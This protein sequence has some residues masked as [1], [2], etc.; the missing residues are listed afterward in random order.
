MP[1]SEM[2]RILQSRDRGQ[3]SATAP[4]QGLTLWRVDY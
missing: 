1:A 4:P 3:A 2:T